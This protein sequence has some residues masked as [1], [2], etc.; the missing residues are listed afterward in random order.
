MRESSGRGNHD[1]GESSAQQ[2]KTAFV[3]HKEANP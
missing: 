1:G 2:N 3:S